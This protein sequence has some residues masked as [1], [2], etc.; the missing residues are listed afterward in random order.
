LNKTKPSV[1]YKIIA[2]I[3]I[4][5][6]ALMPLAT[7]IAVLIRYSFEKSI[8]DIIIAN[9]VYIPLLLAGIGALKSMRTGFYLYLTSCIFSFVNFMLHATAKLG[10]FSGIIAVIFGISG[11]H[12]W[13]SLFGAT[14]SYYES[15][16]FQRGEKGKSVDE[17]I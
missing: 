10:S 13:M 17:S 6:G 16:K 14:I 2:Y 12:L 9:L 3:S 15:K 5:I 8:V 4:V 7:I 1:G 11:F